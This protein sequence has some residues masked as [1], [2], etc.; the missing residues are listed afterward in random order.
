MREEAANPEA[1]SPHQIQSKVGLFWWRQKPNF[2]DD[3]SQHVVELISGKPVMWQDPKNAELFA[4]GS[5]ADR[6]LRTHDQPREGKRPLLWGT[7]MLGP[8]DVRLTEIVDIRALRGPLS[9]TILG[10]RNLPLGDP[11]LF[12]SDLNLPRPECDGKIGVI[13]HITQ[14]MDRRV[15]RQ[16]RRSG[17]FRFID[18]ARSAPEVIADIARCRHVYSSSLHGLIVSDS[19]GIPNTWLSGPNIHRTPEFKFFDYGLSISRPFCKPLDAVSI[20]DH[21]SSLPTKAIAELPYALGIEN[22]KA[23]LKSAFPMELH[24]IG[25]F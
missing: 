18:A 7:G 9:A 11:G 23:A 25:S 15:L 21:S 5:L 10:V 8:V 4:I 22:S 17:R 20:L 16:L 19:F 6:I 3:L 14:G 13:L 1:S 2:G 24:E 12:A